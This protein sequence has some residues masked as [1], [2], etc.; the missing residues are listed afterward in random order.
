MWYNKIKEVIRIEY[1]N[2]YD[3]LKY[4]NLETLCTIFFNFDEDNAYFNVR[5]NYRTSKFAGI[6]LNENTYKRNNEL[7]KG[8][9]R[10]N[11]EMSSNGNHI[12]KIRKD[13]LKLDDFISLIYKRIQKERLRYSDEEFEKII[14]I[15][16]FGLRGSSDFT[17]RFYSVDIKRSIQSQYYLNCIIKLL[18][19]LSDLRQ[20]N[21]NF[22]ELQNEYYSNKNKRNTQIRINLRYF[23][24]KISYDLSMINIYKDNILKSN[25]EKI[26]KIKIGVSSEFFERVYFYIGK[27]LSG[28]EK[29]DDEY[30]KNM[31]KEL[32]FDDFDSGTNRSISVVNLAK[33]LYPDECVCC[34]DEY[35]IKDRSF[36]MR[37]T[38]KFYFEIHHV[39]SF[40][41]DKK[42]DQIDNLVKLCPTCHRA[43]TK[44]RAY[45]EYQKDLI[46]KILDNS[47]N[48][49]NYV[50]NFFEDEPSISEMEEFVYE[51]LA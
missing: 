23:C 33:V 11:F 32:N 46:K 13:N 17:S 28:L 19:N 5:S 50:K 2:I 10:L 15:T 30:I 4:A 16:L 14:L 35:D 51:N 38:D 12:F 44:G 42:G 3:I 47:E 41:K 9:T 7:L 40:S 48:A 20:L 18:T 1:N 24:E 29:V 37:K 6:K 39:I 25:K 49:R 34:K 36:I 27:I 43:L 8:F 22:R 21:L 45:E 26:H 31:R